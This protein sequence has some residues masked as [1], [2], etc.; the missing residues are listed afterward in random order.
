M[1]FLY[2]DKTEL[3][4]QFMSNHMTCSIYLGSV[5]DNPEGIVAEGQFLNGDIIL[6]K[7]CVFDFLTIQWDNISLSQYDLDLWLPSSLPVSLTSKFFL[8]KLFD[9][10]N[11]LFRIIA[12]NPQN[13]KVR[14]I[15][16]TYKL[17]QPM[18]STYIFYQEEEV[19]SSDVRT[20]HLEIT[21]SAPD[22]EVL[23]EEYPSRI[24]YCVNPGEDVPD[25]TSDEEMPDLVTN[26]DL[27]YENKEAQ[28]QKADQDFDIDT[29]VA[30]QQSLDLCTGYQQLTRDQ[31]KD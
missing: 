4:F 8:R 6:Y 24:K 10:P 20:P 19:V 12:Y 1:K 22:E 31:T 9:N 16:S 7:E 2:I 18:M 27:T 13:G 5:Y 25:L 15:I 14:P 3:Y 28:E 21:S 17:Y 29:E 11:T 23:Y 30:I 26:P